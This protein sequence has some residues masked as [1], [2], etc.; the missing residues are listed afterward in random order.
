M[1]N[2]SDEHASTAAANK[3]R[4]LLLLAGIMMNNR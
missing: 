1:L 3:M 2:A 4:T